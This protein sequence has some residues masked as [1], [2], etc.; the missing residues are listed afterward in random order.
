WISKADALQ[1]NGFAPS[2]KIIWASGSETWKR[3]AQLGVWVNGS[4]ESLGEQEDPR[5]ETLAGFELKWLKLTHAEGFA[6]DGMQNL[7]TYRLVPRDHGPERAGRNYF[8][9]RSGSGFELAR[10]LNQWLAERTATRGGGSR[11]RSTATTGV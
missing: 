5:I 6:E 11:Q 4:A 8:F 7:A 10:A 9:W 1:D 3:L 2:S